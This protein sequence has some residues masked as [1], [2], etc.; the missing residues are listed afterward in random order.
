MIIETNSW[1]FVW[2]ILTC[3]NATAQCNWSPGRSF[4]LIVTVLF[5]VQKCEQPVKGEDILAF[6]STY[7]FM[8]ESI[9]HWLM[10]LSWHYL[11]AALSKTDGH[12]LTRKEP[13]DRGRLTWPQ[14]R[15]VGWRQR[16]LMEGLSELLDLLQPW[17]PFTHF[18]P[19]LHSRWL[20]N[21]LSG[22]YFRG[23]QGLSAV[24]FQEC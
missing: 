18:T 22:A 5:P 15:L 9:W 2:I 11:F 21:S 4:D 23:K 10:G 24:F 20:L 12:I 8:L 19:L 7:N 17:S 14:A 13:P 6:F 16:V 1:V 3:S